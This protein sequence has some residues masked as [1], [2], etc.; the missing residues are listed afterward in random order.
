MILVSREVPGNTTNVTT[1]IKANAIKNGHATIKLFL[2]II[3]KAY[4]GEGDALLDLVAG[5][6]LA[7][8][9]LISCALCPIRLVESS[10]IAL[11]ILLIA[12][13]CSPQDFLI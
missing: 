13:C 4:T 6:T 7:A 8:V 2:S 12:Y 1:K 11:L 10:S 3:K 9:L 5:L